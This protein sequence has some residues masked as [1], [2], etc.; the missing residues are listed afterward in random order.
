MKI[1]HF[2]W[3]KP[4]Q[5][6]ND[7]LEENRHNGGW[8]SMQYHCM[9]W[10]LSCLKFKQFYRDVEL[11]TDQKGKGLLIDT[12]GL[13]YSKV[14]VCLDEMNYLPIQMWALPKI[15]TYSLQHEPFIHADGDVYIW[16]KFNPQFEQVPLISQHLENNFTYYKDASI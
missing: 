2:Y 13:P 16:E 15:F 4:S 9:S 7:T 12:L 10:A 11:H 3:S 5:Q 1:I 8:L 6:Q 14:Y